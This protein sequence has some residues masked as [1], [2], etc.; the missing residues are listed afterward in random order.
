MYKLFK[1]N[2]DTLK[3]L[4]LFP[5]EVDRQKKQKIDELLKSKNQIDSLEKFI[6]TG[7]TFDG[8]K[9]IDTVFPAFHK[10]VFI[11]HSHNDRYL[12]YLLAKKLENDFNLSVFLDEYFWGSA[13]E[14]LR[15]IDDKHCK[16]E[17]DVFYDYKSRNLTTSHV[18][19]MLSTA[20][21]K[22]IDQCEIVL[23]LE[24]SESAPNIDKQFE[25][26][27]Y[28]MS[29]WVFQE[30]LFSS[31]VQKYR[32]SYS[33]DENGKELVIKEAVEVAYKLPSMV[34]LN[35]DDIIEW[36]KRYLKDTQHGKMS[37]Y[38]NAL[39][40]LYAIKEPKQPEPLNS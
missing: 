38:H 28:T 19:A 37:N 15:K 1:I 14:L 2:L 34:E 12:A 10:D 16:K 35:A 21:I 5:A 7:E 39:G 18:H 24:T 32:K 6:K 22:A 23:F 8:K 13:D 27:V 4:D 20:I 9:I 33:K 26:N 36:K 30:I 11:S 29:P 40:Y 31:L 17:D 25:N 3:K